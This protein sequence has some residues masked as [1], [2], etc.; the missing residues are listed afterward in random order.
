MLTPKFGIRR[1]CG[2]L[3]T[4]AMAVFAPAVSV[5]QDWPSKPIRM[6]V[7]FPP[8]S[9]PDVLGRAVA[10]GL[11]QALGQTIVPDN[12]SGVGGILGSDVVAKSPPDGYTVLVTSGSSMAI[13]VHTLDKLPF[14]PATDLVPVAAGA[15]IELF[16]VARA[17]LPFKTYNEFLAY[18]RANPGKLSYASPGVGSAPHVATEMLKKE[19]NI[20]AV[21]VPYRGAAPAL[22][23]LLGGVTDFAFDPGIA[24]SHVR[25]GRLTLLAIGSTKRS[26]LFP[27]T[28][29][30]QELGLK[31][32]DAGTTHAF[33]A[34]AGTPAAIVERLNREINK[35]LLLPE[36]SQ[37][38]RA[39]GAEPTPM[40][41]A[42]LRAQIESDSKRFG[43][44]IKERGIK[45]L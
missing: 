40:S 36:V 15:R 33:W 24:L 35:V 43:D 23:D 9:S 7:S 28:P 31:N 25:A 13:S 18:A 21:H 27:D 4:A 42:G 26:A 10:P 44:I 41:P 11:S 45:E 17:N 2:V 3:A 6:V 39:M 1:A 19:T 38:I 22:Q 32:F 34:P 5:A 30:L 8:G 20:F 37:Q 16:L 12:R 14:N 29:T